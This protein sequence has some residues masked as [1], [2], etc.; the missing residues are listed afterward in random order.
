MGLGL[1][2]LRGFR[3]GRV[4]GALMALDIVLLYHRITGPGLG[5]RVTPER[6]AAQLDV[7]DEHADVVPL[8]EHGRAGRHSRPRVAITFDD[9]YDDN[10]TAAAPMLDER[11]LSATF[12]VASADRL[13]E[14]W[15]DSMAHTLLDAPSRADLLELSIAA[16]PVKI[17]VRSFA[18]RERA[19]RLSKRR[20]RGSPEE[21]PATLA[22]IVSQTGNS[23]AACAEHRRL[24]DD[25]LRT[26][27]RH[28][29]IGS[30]S[31]THVM[32]T[33]VD[34]RR[35]REELEGSRAELESAIGAPIA[36]VAYPFGGTRAYDDRVVAAAQRA[37]FERACINVRGPAE[38]SDP[39]RIPRYAVHDW[40][41]D[42][43]AEHLRSWLQTP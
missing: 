21:I 16:Q 15:A 5:P 2:Y 33:A 19:L 26:L 22:A 35:L 13:G 1:R 10:A 39:F 14:L 4:A 11:G 34:D 27:A 32:L 7:L 20:L 17:D 8:A 38:P 31:R 43:F 41:A 3:A 37:G 24:T 29:E 28:H 30:H 36:S 42:V 6:F 9:G 18:G 40:T 25:E 12:F 23:P